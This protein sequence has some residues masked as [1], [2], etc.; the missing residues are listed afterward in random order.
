[1][2]IVLARQHLRQLER[3]HVALGG[4]HRDHR[5]GLRHL[6]FHLDAKLV[7]RLRVFDRLV[8]LRPA[9]QLLLELRLLFQKTLGLDVVI[10]EV[11]ERRVA[12]D[13]R[14]A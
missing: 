8:R 11:G 6:V 14:D 9:R 7:E 10:P 2:A 4:L 5:L 12:L 1:V 3:L 13:Q